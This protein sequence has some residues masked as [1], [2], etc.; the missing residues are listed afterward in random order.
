M[1]ENRILRYK[2]DRL[3]EAL[4]RDLRNILSIDGDAP[5]LHIVEALKELHKGTL[6]TTRVPHERDFFSCF[7]IHGEVLKH[8]SSSALIGEYDIAEGNGPTWDAEDDR[9][10]RIGNR[11]WRVVETYHFLYMSTRLQVLAHVIPNIEHV[12]PESSDVGRDEDE[13]TRGEPTDVPHPYSKQHDR[14]LNHG[15]E[16]EENPHVEI[17]HSPEE[18][19]PTHPFSEHTS[20]AL[21]LKVLLPKRFHRR[22]TGERIHHAG[23]DFGILLIGPRLPLCI[24]QIEHNRDS[25][26]EDHPSHH[27]DT[28]RRREERKD[29]DESNGEEEERQEVKPHAVDHAFQSIC[30]TTDF[31]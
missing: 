24:T 7:D 21:I 14:K 18:P 27:R 17:P 23:S 19:E 5:R 28:K 10:R 16:H 6:P 4:L 8:R 30:A 25:R 13:V 31:T 22:I 11:K 1:E 9:L 29:N 2:A 20:V 12:A 26:E 3:S 15:D